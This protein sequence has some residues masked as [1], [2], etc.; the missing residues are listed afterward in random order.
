[1][2]DMTLAGELIRRKEYDTARRV[3]LPIAGTNP[4]AAAWL[5]RLDQLSPPAPPSKPVTRIVMGAVSLVTFVLA[6]AAIAL[7]YSAIQTSD[8]NEAVFFGI[9]GIVLLITTYSTWRFKPKA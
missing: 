5:D 2:D 6:L 4:T 1:M 8:F 3:L 9:G 7:A